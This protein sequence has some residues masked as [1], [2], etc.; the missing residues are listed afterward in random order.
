MGSDRKEGKSNGSNLI[1]PDFFQALVERLLAKCR[2]VETQ[3][4]HQK[5]NLQLRSL[6]ID[7]NPAETLIRKLMNHL[8]L[9][10]QYYFLKSVLFLHLLSTKSSSSENRKAEM[11][12]SRKN[13]PRK[14]SQ[15]FV[16]V[17]ILLQC[18]SQQMLQTRIISVPFFTVLHQ[19]AYL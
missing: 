15:P 17:H 18:V 19:L 9:P 4:K 1:P 14:L 8:Y 16:E 6:E 3:A 12:T 10:N 11:M 2:P 5:N 7:R 13:I